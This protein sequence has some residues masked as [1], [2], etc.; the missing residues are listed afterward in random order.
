MRGLHLQ[1]LRTFQF[2][3]IANHNISRKCVNR[4]DTKSLICLMVGMRQCVVN[5][6]I[7]TRNM[8]KVRNH[9]V[10]DAPLLPSLHNANK[11]I[12][13]K[14]FWSMGQ[15]IYCDRAGRKTA[16]HPNYILHEQWH[17]HSGQMT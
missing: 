6:M 15:M 5:Y 8:T 11:M 16:G 3:V 4:A 9:C 13:Q 1:G 10:L 12:V 14:A 7:V 2:A 17:C